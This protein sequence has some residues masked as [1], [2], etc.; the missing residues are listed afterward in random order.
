M[1]TSFPFLVTNEDVSVLDRHQTKTESGKEFPHAAY[2]FVPDRDMPSTW[3]LKLFDEPGDVPDSPSIRLTAAAAQAL[4]SSGFR[5]QPVQIPASARSAVKAKVRAAWLKARRNADQD[6][7]IADVPASIRNEA[8]QTNSFSHV[9]INLQP[10][11]RYDTLEGRRH[12]VI[13]MIMLTEGVH[14]GSCGPLLYPGAELGK[15]PQVWNHKPIVVYHPT[16]NGQGVSACDPVILNNRKIGVILNSRFEDSKLHAEAWLEESRVKKVDNRILEAL[17]AGKV[18]ELS[19]GLFTDNEQQ[20]G[21]W[22]GEDYVAVARNYRPDHLAILPDKKGACSIEDGAGLLRVNQ[23]SFDTIRGLLHT[24]IHAAFPNEE[25]IFIADVFGDFFVYGVGRDS[26][27]KLFKQDYTSTDATVTLEGDPEEVVR[28]I[29]YRTTGGAFVGNVQET[30]MDKKKFVEALISNTETQWGESDKGWLMSLSEERLQK[31]EPVDNSGHTKG[32]EGKAG[33]GTRARAGI[34]AAEAKGFTH[35][36]IGVATNRSASVIGQIKSGEIQNPP[37]DFLTRIA[38]LNR[39]PAKKESNMADNQD[40]N[41]N[42]DGKTPKTPKPEGALVAN[43]D[44]AKVDPPKPLTLQEYINNAPSELR[45]VLTSSV[46]AHAI[47]K[48]RLIDAVVSNARSTFTQEQLGSFDLET[49]KSLALIAVED[50][51][52][53]NAPNYLGAGLDVYL[54]SDSGGADE[55]E[56]SPLVM[57]TMNFEKAGAK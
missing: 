25:F 8:I 38:A 54:P 36:E 43:T 1:Q 51:P 19:T 9:T 15:T 52:T 7:S 22:N 49:L 32:L 10:R 35:E 23:A 42:D 6:V 46:R 17:Q 16:I 21:T 26:G 24:A 30:N 55:D 20:E 31:M 40:P 5:G 12:M 11:I 27:S 57:P 14:A 4:S 39:R 41:V 48:K 37:D 53:V 18:V 34:R 28:V 56:E 47:E 3:K 44:P 29:E 2:A 13:P 50:K 33:N 45:D